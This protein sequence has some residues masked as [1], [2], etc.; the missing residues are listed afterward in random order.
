MQSAELLTVGREH[1]IVHALVLG[2]A[3]QFATGRR[4]RV[5]SVAPGDSAQ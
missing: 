1:E 4:G 5:I 3:A 2:D